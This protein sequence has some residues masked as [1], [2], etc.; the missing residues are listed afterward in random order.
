M[1]AI[2]EGVAVV[3]GG[4]KGIGLAIVRGLCKQFKGSVLLTARSEEN[5]KAAVWLLE[6]E[7]LKPVYEK[8]DIL[9]QESIM[10][11]KSRVEKKYGGIDILVNN[12]GIAFKNASTDPLPIK[13]HVTLET[14]FFATLFLTNS[15]LPIMNKGSHICMVSS[16]SSRLS[17]ISQDKTH[18]IRL[19]MTN[20]DIK[21][22]E[23][24]SLL[25]EYLN[26]VDKDDYSV[27]PKDSAYSMSKVGITAVTRAIGRK[28]SDDSREIII[29]SCCP[30]FV[31]TDMTS[32]KGVL[33]PDQG[34]VTPLKLCLL[35]S[36]TASGDYYKD[37]KVVD[38]VNS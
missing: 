30:G 33:T 9:S 26:A 16:M 15:L 32:H 28:L 34:A 38:W 10:D 24:V 2:V 11:F 35:P 23:V 13:A 37:E 20:P 29:N 6:K 4:N 36:G 22:E 27:W 17:K 3:T 14:N 25:K 21:E 7:G 31:D 12:A 18:P 19:R 1:A 5:G 8:L